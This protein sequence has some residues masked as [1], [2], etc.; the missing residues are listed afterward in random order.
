MLLLLL[1]DPRPNFY[2]PVQPLRSP[3]DQPG[4][5]GR[6]GPG[7]PEERHCQSRAF[8]RLFLCRNF[9]IELTIK[10]LTMS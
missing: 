8:A 4:G 6:L 1:D 5:R 3:R 10:H 9:N 7:R 2:A